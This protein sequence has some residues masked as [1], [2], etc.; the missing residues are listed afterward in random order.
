MYLRQSA[1]DSD[2][3]S[4]IWDNAQQISS[5]IYMILWGTR[6]WWYN[7]LVGN[8]TVY[9]HVFVPGNHTSRCNFRRGFVLGNYIT[10]TNMK[11][12]H[13]H[14]YCWLKWIEMWRIELLSFFIYNFDITCFKYGIHAVVESTYNGARCIFVSELSVKSFEKAIVFLNSM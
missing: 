8:M 12:R 4:M 6:C 7:H 11:Y 3:D 10:H 1:I 14:V 9:L 5:H 2:L 13:G